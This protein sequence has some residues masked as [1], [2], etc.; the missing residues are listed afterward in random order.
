MTCS[1]R[2]SSVGDCEW[3]DQNQRSKLT[4]GKI[5]VHSFLRFCLAAESCFVL[6]IGIS[7]L[8][9]VGNPLSLPFLLDNEEAAMYLAKSLLSLLASVSVVAAVLATPAASQEP[10]V[11]SA[12]AVSQITKLENDAVKADLAGDVSF[13]ERNLA[14]TW[15]GGTSWGTWDTKQSLLAALK[16]T[17]NNHT[18]SEQ[19]TDLKIRV[20]GNTAVATYKTTYDAMVLGQHRAA[21]VLSTDT[22]V[23]QD[24]T[25]KQVASHSSEIAK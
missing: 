7:H 2:S 6:G 5:T 12:A 3:P 24:G 4:K 21:T 13:Y 15:T 25:W 1:V 9:W 17:K 22:F 20:Y 8:V 18:N 19:I 23:K 10:A 16:D 11:P 14:D